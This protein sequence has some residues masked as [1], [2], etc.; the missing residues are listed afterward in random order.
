[1]ILYVAAVAALALW[2]S[3]FGTKEGYF[4]DYISLKAIQPIKGIFTL[5]IIV[6]HFV[7]Y[8][9]LSG[10]LDNTYLLLKRYLGQMVVVPFLFYSGYGVIESFNKKGVAYIHTMP[11]QRI[12][13]VFLQMNM[14]LVPFWLIKIAQGNTYSIREILLVCVGWSSIGNSNWYIFAIL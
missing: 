6:S 9:T 10:P 7:T 3:D 8:T 4:R 11:F 14:A 5:L 12:F 1:M 2:G 13:K